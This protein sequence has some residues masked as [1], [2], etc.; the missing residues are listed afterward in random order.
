MFG[1]DLSVLTWWGWILCGVGLAVLGSRAGKSE[2]DETRGGFLRTTV[3][4]AFYLAAVV[5]A[6]IGVMRFL[7]P[8]G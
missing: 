7:R 2:G 4:I 3:S 8:Y 1:L 5:C 6:F